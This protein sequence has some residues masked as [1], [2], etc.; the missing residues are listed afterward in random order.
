MPKNKRI[1]LSDNVLDEGMHDKLVLRRKQLEDMLSG[2][3]E[4]FKETENSL[5]HNR[6]FL[7]MLNGRVDPLEFELATRVLD[8]TETDLFELH[9]DIKNLEKVTNE[10]DGVLL[11][12]AHGRDSEGKIRQVEE[13]FNSRS[14][15]IKSGSRLSFPISNLE[16]I[17]HTAR[18]LEHSAAALLELKVGK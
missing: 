5:V 3:R 8:A 18:V 16:E 11:K 10:M 6:A 2:M 9:M 1:N 15:S 17:K 4:T 13:F 14:N 12:I 7:H